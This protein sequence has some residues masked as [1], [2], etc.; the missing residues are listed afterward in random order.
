MLHCFWICDHNSK[1]PQTGLSWW[2]EGVVTDMMVRVMM[3]KKEENRG[4]G[5]KGKQ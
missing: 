5:R 2:D 4:R 1:S 3:E